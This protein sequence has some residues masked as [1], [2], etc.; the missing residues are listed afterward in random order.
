[1]YRTD[2]IEALFNLKNI[3]HTKQAVLDQTKP[4][5]PIAKNIKILVLCLLCNGFGDVAF[6]FKL[7]NYLKEWYNADVH[8][9]TTKP[10]HFKTLG[11]SENV[12]GL[13]YK[14]Q[15]QCRRLKTLK[16]PP[17]LKDITY[18]LLFVA[19]LVADSEIMPG[20]IKSMFPY[21][22]EWNTYF[23]SEYN[24]TL[25]KGFD[26]N[27][28]VGNGRDGLFFTSLDEVPRR[29]SRLPNPYAM[30]YL[31][32]QCYNPVKCILSFI[33]MICKKYRKIYPNLDVVA[34]GWLVEELYTVFNDKEEIGM[35]QASYPNINLLI[36][37][38]EPYQ[39]T[40]GPGNTLTIRGDI[41]PVSNRVM[42]G[43]IINSIDDLVTTG[44]QS[45]T[46][47]LSYCP[48]KNVWYQICGWKEDFADNLAEL[49]PQP[50]FW[51][52]KTSCGDIEGINFKARFSKFVHDWDFRVLGRKKLDK[53]MRFVTDR[54]EIQDILDVID[55][56]RSLK[57]MKHKLEDLIDV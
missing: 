28:G 44:D 33:T 53:V 21:S 20:D 24:D 48:N 49:L 38:E 32:D 27:T 4:G 19:P 17:E 40:K 41:L 22:N 36:K 7:C 52:V 8:I 9:A 15:P 30:V 3:K 46:E 57:T 39:L 1:M 42:A 50:Y 2:V 45:L 16:I 11:Q 25:K 43:L 18:D 31:N 13:I 26:F 14:K 47:V 37:N 10:E 51:S 12:Y 23:F 55:R 29:D 54:V 35:I 34:P 56:S 6:A 5:M